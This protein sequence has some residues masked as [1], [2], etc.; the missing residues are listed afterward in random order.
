MPELSWADAVRFGAASGAIAGITNQGI[1][2]LRDLAGFQNTRKTQADERLHQALL[3]DEADHAAARET[4]LRIAEG[5]REWITYTWVREF[6]FDSDYHGSSLVSPAL[7]SPSQVIHDVDR[8]ATGHPTKSVRLLARALKD[9]SDDR[10]NAIEGGISSVPDGDD[11]LS[12]IN[13]IEE[14]IEVIHD[15]EV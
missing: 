6:G 13:Q 9:Q 14:V 10:H 4:F 12:W 11:F 15:P 5:A 8:I 1:G 2:W 7:T 3:R